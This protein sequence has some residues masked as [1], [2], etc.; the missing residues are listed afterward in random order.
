M[1]T[2]TVVLTAMMALTALACEPEMPKPGL[3]KLNPDG[4]TEPQPED[5]AETDTD[6]E[7]DA[8]EEPRADDEEWLH[9]C[10]GI[11]SKNSPPPDHDDGDDESE[12]DPNCH[13]DCFGGVSCQEGGLHLMGFGPRPC[14]RYSDPWPGPGP[15]CSVQKLFE[16][17]GDCAAAWD[18]R[19]EECF[20][21]VRNSEAG[22]RGLDHLFPTFCES[23]LKLAGDPCEEDEDCRPSADETRLACDLDSLTCVEEPRPEAPSS[24]G[25]DCGLGPEYAV[26]DVWDT[27]VAGNSC[28]WCH[29]IYDTEQGCVRQA[30]TMR[31]K[32]D[33]DCPEGSVCVCVDATGG[34]GL[35]SQFCVQ[36]ETRNWEA[37]QE[38]LTCR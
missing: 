26:D 12:C 19:Y 29:A 30:C 2:L 35:P 25:G 37:R 10:M 22:L 13:W 21:G 1:R 31:C 6:V 3:I 36:A 8:V 11:D 23:G 27:V 4:E 33:E 15:V 9:R 18:P 34:Y 38:W 28:E 7:Q 17:D 16:C 32:L 14:C 24:Y 5:P 20:A